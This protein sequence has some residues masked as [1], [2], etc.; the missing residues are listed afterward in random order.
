MKI[1]PPLK[2]IAEDTRLRMAQVLR[3][4]ELNVNELVQLLG[5]GQPR[6]SRHLKILADAGLLACRREGQWVF[7]RA[8]ES[9]PG[10]ALLAA[11]S[12]LL[13]QEEGLVADVEQARL[14]LAE[15][16][17]ATRRFFDSIS[18]DW[19]QLS[20]EV[21]G[22]LDLAGAIV[23]RM[24]LCEVAADLGCGTGQLLHPLLTRAERVIGVDSSPRMLEAASRRLASNR[25]E[26]SLRLGSLEHLPVA[27][28]E[29]D[30]GLCCLVLHHL[31][32]PAAGLAEAFR[33][34]RPGGVFIIA[35][36]LKHAQDAMHTRYGDLWLGFEREALAGLAR[37]AGLLPGE[38]VLFP[39]N[40]GLAIQL[41]IC[42]KP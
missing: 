34:L 37:G 22:S 31:S 24:P 16:G 25:R 41:L 8:V 33:V 5:M 21:L 39:V 42:T 13:E 20:R 27:D 23:S 11:L 1:L 12:P 4:V 17:Q 6:V 18:H 10:L 15:R 30:F 32:D 38:S 29:V 19:D 2:A 14:I 7:Y 26:A 3:H 36:F 28:G 9:G 35:D 40:K